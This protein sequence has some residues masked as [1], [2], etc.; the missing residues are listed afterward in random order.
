VL[1]ELI[2]GGVRKRISAAMA[3]RLLENLQHEGGVARA[4]YELAY[5]YLIDLRRVDEQIRQANKHMAVAVKLSR[6]TT[7]KIFGVG[8][9]MKATVKGEVGDVTR[10]E[11]RDHFAAYNGTAPIEASSGPRKVY[12]LSRRSNR[13]L[14]SAIHMAAVTQ[15]SHPHSPGRGYYDR[16]IAEGKTGKEALH[17]LLQAPQ[18]LVEDVVLHNPQNTAIVPDC[19]E[20]QACARQVTAHRLLK[21][22]M[23]AAAEHLHNQVGVERDGQ[24]S[25]DAIQLDPAVC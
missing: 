21:V 6:T 19:L 23:P 10:F 13:R 4:R 24:Q 22:D 7:T 3:Q 17:D 5:D 18:R 8:P 20:H 1:C 25:L 15:V 14:N 9:Y 12:R 11:N 16:K 2:P